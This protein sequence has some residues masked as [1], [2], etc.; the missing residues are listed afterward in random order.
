MVIPRTTPTSVAAAITPQNRTQAPD[1]HDDEGSR[2]NFRAHR[3]MYAQSERAEQQSGRPTAER[4]DC[5]HVRRKR[6]AERTDN[7]GVLHARPHHAAERRSVDNE[8]GRGDRREYYAENE[9]R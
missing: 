2:K 5:G 4:R 9:E 6:N 8:P 1:D 7:V 3:R